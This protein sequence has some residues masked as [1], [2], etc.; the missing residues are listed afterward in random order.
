MIFLAEKDYYETLGVSKNASQEEIKQAYKNLAK[1]YH[2]DVSTEQNAEHKFKE[3]NEAFSVLG[4]EQKRKNYDAFGSAGE[5]FS[6][7]QGFNYGDFSHMDFDFQDLFSEMGFGGFDEFFGRARGSGR[8]RR[9]RKGEDIIIKL[10]VSFMEAAKG[11]EKEIELKRVEECSKC[12]GKG[13]L[14]DKGRKTC[15]TCRGRGIET[16]TQK[17]FFGIFQTQMTCS[18]CH[19][20]GEIITEPCLECNGMGKVSRKRKISV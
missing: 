17:T 9:Q 5:R 18:Q 10:S 2:P 15:P 16:K 3:I 14:S 20:S 4:D 6:G 11:A 7:F 1:K 19:G 13:T 12:H 8:A